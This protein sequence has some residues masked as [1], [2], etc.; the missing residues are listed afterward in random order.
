MQPNRMR[1]ILLVVVGLG[2]CA[3]CACSTD[4]SAASD[5][6]G[7]GGNGGATAT[8]GAPAGFGGA[9]TAGGASGSGGQEIGSG[10]ASTGSGGHG[11]DAG[12]YANVGV[13]GQRGK[14]TADAASFDGYEE[15]YLIGEQGFGSDV[16][17]VRFDL[18]RIGD[19]PAGCT[20]CAWA[21]LLEYSNPHV[22]ADA[23]GVCALSDLGLAATA[24]ARRVGSRIALGFAKQLGG[25]HG[26]ARMTYDDT[27]GTWDVAG[28]ATWSETTKAFG[29]DYRDGLCN[30]GP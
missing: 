18:K 15:R 10:G 25:A 13:C 29:F 17:V 23:D 22:I 14:A 24:I 21:H 3:L 9:T 26:S 11:D 19:A 27:T 7:G 2:G 12:T 1:R 28:N 30:Y 20:V 5:T 6:H 8:G 4:D 16:C